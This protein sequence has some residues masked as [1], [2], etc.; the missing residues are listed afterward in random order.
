[1]HRH[2]SAVEAAR[3]LRPRSSVYVLRPPP[4]GRAQAWRTP[5]KS[6][7]RPVYAEPRDNLPRDH[8]SS[9]ASAAA[10][11][12]SAASL[13]SAEPSASASSPP[14]STDSSTHRPAEH[15]PNSAPNEHEVP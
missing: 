3:G 11:A 5:E 8:P 6:C 15:V 12:A 9:G 1:N 4:T 14:S 10:S 2:R 7:R 13:A